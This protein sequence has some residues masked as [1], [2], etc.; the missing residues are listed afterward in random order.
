MCLCE[1]W[2]AQVATKD[3]LFRLLHFLF[4]VGSFL[5]EGLVKQQ[6][7]GDEVGTS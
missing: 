7:V 2:D 5:D 1:I 3:W 4:D 6:W